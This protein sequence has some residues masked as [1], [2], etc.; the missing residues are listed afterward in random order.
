MKKLQK[1]ILP[2]LL[3]I[4]VFIIYQFY[5]ATSDKLG[6]FDDFD[7]NN[8]AVKEIRVQLLA[9]R[10][11]TNNGADATFYVSDRNNKVMLVSGSLSLPN[12]FE[13]AKIVILRGHLS[14]NSF[15]A[16][17]VLLN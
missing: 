9:D 4:V 6:S 14:G 10:G 15:H 8:T 11:I 1:L 2:V 13:N 17:E 5:F 16:H 7:P 12:D 3:V